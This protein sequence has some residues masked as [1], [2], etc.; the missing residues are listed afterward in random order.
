MI[1]DPNRDPRSD[2]DQVLAPDPDFSRLRLWGTTNVCLIH[3]W[4]RERPFRPANIQPSNERSMASSQDAAS[5]PL[6]HALDGMGYK[7]LE[8]PPELENLLEAEDAPV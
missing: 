2:V 8:L 7:L 1:V 6:S 4:T 3:L 5:F